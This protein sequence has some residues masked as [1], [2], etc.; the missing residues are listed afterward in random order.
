MVQLIKL[1]SDVV[2]CT[3]DALGYLKHD[4]NLAGGDCLKG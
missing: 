4:A 3:S 1:Y 2:Y